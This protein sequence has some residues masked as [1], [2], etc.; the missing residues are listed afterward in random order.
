VGRPLAHR[1][2][3]AA[4]ARTPLDLLVPAHRVVGADGRVRGASPGSI[5]AR[6]VGFE[7]LQER[8]PG[9]RKNA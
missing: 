4:M 6:L 5:R 2:V 7:R 9:R 8:A 1:A 3:A